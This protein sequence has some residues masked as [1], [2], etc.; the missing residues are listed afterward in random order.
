MRRR[1]LDVLACPGCSG[2]LA[3]IGSDGSDDADIQS[4]T[5]QCA[6]CAWAF[7]VVGGIPR[8]VP[9]ENYASSF[10]YQW[11][12]FRAE[13]IDSINHTRLSETRFFS[14]TG[15]TRE[16]LRGTWILDVGCGAGRFLDVV[17]QEPCEVVGLDLSNATD[18]AY[19][20]LGSR[21]NVHLV[22][23]S[24]DEMPFKR[25]AF[26]GCY[27]IGVIQHTP[28]PGR[29]LEALGGAVKPG[30]RVAVTIYEQ[31]RWTKLNPK[32]LM[33]P[34]TTRVNRRALLMLIKALMPV[35]FPLTEV[36][37]RIPGVGRLFRFIIPVAN[38]VDERNLTIGQRYRWAIMDTF[39]MLAP[40]YDQ[41]QTESAAS[42]AL[43]RSGMTN[44]RR[45]G[46]PGLT[47]VATK[48]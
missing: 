17:S 16:W 28:A 6:G 14:E 7:P 18:A 34:L 40:E 22:Q 42:T 45:L 37:F 41:P 35:L 3:V 38:Y 25:G 24:I 43:E 15:W 4:G 20:T 44:I 29:S 9:A 33:R 48:R 10:G 39:D 19:A 47:L 1:L 27:C 31:R 26:D 13:Q 32:Y 12:R 8:F 46:T 5:L 2:T 30:G 11:N 23:A 36:M 21:P